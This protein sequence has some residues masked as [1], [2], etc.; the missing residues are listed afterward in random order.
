MKKFT[1]LLLTLIATIISYG[2]TIETVYL[3]VSESTTN[4]GFR[5]PNNQRHPHSWSIADPKHII[6]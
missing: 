2:Q 5:S 6:I 3:G 4:K 1:F